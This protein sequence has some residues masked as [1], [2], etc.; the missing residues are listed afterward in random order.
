MHIMID[1]ETL[2]TGVLP[3]ILSIGWCLFDDTKTHG[4]GEL[5]PIIEVGA[6][7]DPKTALWWMDQPDAARK[8]QTGAIRTETL[9][10][11][12]LRLGTMISESKIK[13]VWA[14][15]VSFDL[16]ILRDWYKEYEMDTP[17]HHR[18]ERCM[19][20]FYD[21]KVESVASTVPHAIA[22]AETVQKVWRLFN[23]NS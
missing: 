7:A 12:L 13:G 19:R 9:E 18:A 8:L 1:I 14:K 4:S 22:Q 21:L 2:G 6:T 23:A 16:R 3:T 11:C 20:T 15:G 5:F 17:W 10:T